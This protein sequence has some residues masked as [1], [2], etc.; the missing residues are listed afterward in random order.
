MMKLHCYHNKWWNPKIH[1]YKVS[2]RDTE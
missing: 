2:R 1:C